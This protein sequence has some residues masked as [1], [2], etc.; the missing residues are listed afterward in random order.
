M[1]RLPNHE[2]AAHTRPSLLIR[3]LMAI[4]PGTIIVKKAPEGARNDGTSCELLQYHLSHWSLLALPDGHFPFDETETSKKYRDALTHLKSAKDSNDDDW[5]AY[6]RYKPMAKDVVDRWAESKTNY[7]HGD[8][9]KWTDWLEKRVFVPESGPVIIV[10]SPESYLSYTCPDNNDYPTITPFRRLL[11]DAG[12]TAKYNLETSFYGGAI[13]HGMLRTPIQ[14]GSNFLEHDIGLIYL[15]RTHAGRTVVVLAGATCPFGTFAAVRLSTDYGRNEINSMAMDFFEGISPNHCATAFF[16]KRIQRPDQL[17]AFGL[18]DPIGIKFIDEL[19]PS[20]TRSDL[21]YRRA[22]VELQL[23]DTTPAIPSSQSTALSQFLSSKG[24]VNII[25]KWYPYDLRDDAYAMQILEYALDDSINYPV[26]SEITDYIEQ[27]MGGIVADGAVIKSQ[28]ERFKKE[29]GNSTELAIGVLD[30]EAVQL[31]DLWSESLKERL[32]EPEIYTKWLDQIYS[33]PSD[34][35]TIVL[36]SPES[37]LGFEHSLADLPKTKLAQLIFYARY[38]NRYQLR[39]ENEGGQKCIGIFDHKI[40]RVLEDTKHQLLTNSRPETDAGFISL[41][42][43]PNGRDILVIAG[44]SWLGTLAG[45]RLLFTQQRPSIDKLIDSYVAGERKQVDIYY[46]CRRDIHSIG[47]DASDS[48]WQHFDDPKDLE[49]DTHN[50]ELEPEFE[51]NRFAASLLHDL[52]DSLDDASIHGPIAVKGEEDSFD[53]KISTTRGKR[54]LTITSKCPIS[55]PGDDDLLCGSKVSKIYKQIRH[56]VQQDAKR[57]NRARF[58]GNY[59]IIGAPGVGKESVAKYIHKQLGL[60][61]QS[62]GILVT[63]NSAGVQSDLVQS[64]L[65]GHVKGAY[66]DAKTAREGR[67]EAAKYGVLFLDEFAVQRVTENHLAEE[68]DALKLQAR[69]LRVMESGTFSPVGSNEEKEVS[70]LFVAATNIAENKAQLDLLISRGYF[71]QDVCDRFAVR[72]RIFELPRL[73]ERPIEIL[74][75]LIQSIRKLYRENQANPPQIIMSVDAVKLLL[76][77]KLTANFRSLIR[78]AEFLIRKLDPQYN[79]GSDGSL[80]VR[81][82]HVLN[83][84]SDMDIDSETKPIDQSE[85]LAIEILT[86]ATESVTN[87]VIPK[88][89][90]DATAIPRNDE[91]ERKCPIE[92]DVVSIPQAK[93][94][95]KFERFT[96]KRS[97]YG[98]NINQKSPAKADALSIISNLVQIDFSNL[99]AEEV[100]QKLHDNYAAL[101]FKRKKYTSKFEGVYRKLSSYFDARTCSNNYQPLDDKIERRIND[102]IDAAVQKDISFDFVAIAFTIWLGIEIRC[103]DYKD[104]C[105]LYREFGKRKPLTLRRDS[106][107][108]TEDIGSRNSLASVMDFIPTRLF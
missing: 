86:S 56:C 26:A 28:L 20:S 78:I 83:A 79:L 45:V 93:C 98:K 60:I 91:T 52:F 1:L 34:G 71:R 82:Y 67:F 76:M 69:L 90:E 36:G 96:A 92:Q 73:A 42:K 81:A 62:T 7:E 6:V 24:P 37:F 33:I 5:Q 103:A 63:V 18:Q 29:S 39:F 95:L 15:G 104:L 32:E 30:P 70:L 47:T 17:R 100:V 66:T 107:Q 54:K 12:Y 8:N 9:K 105:F 85:M 75:G 4:G 23:L 72:G 64:E 94:A 43:G 3:Y 55:M 50:S 102:T 77:Q 41:S 97:S 22:E 108:A 25:T 14:T 88:R 49:I 10:G 87:A 106:D 84:M 13:K 16:A 31:F 40:H 19:K 68:R 48:H 21:F 27:N 38:P 51:R 57:L 2:I 99:G 44:I 80:E 61:R 53:V 74:P 59:F 101:I 58:C 35:A 46:T 11:S 65:F 89:T